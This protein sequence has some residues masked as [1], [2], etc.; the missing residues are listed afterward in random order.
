MNWWAANWGNIASVVGLVISVVAW[1]QAAAATILVQRSQARQ[2]LFQLSLVLERCTHLVQE[3]TAS[4]GTRLPR[5][6]C[7]ELRDALAEVSD[8]LLFEYGERM[9]LRTWIA[10]FYSPMQRTEQASS[11]IR[12]LKTCLI[13]VKSRVTDAIR[14]M[15]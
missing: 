2:R 12:E 1:K 7:D 9:L 15:E 4:T 14:R 11:Q 3:I 10:G 6:R 8:D 13:R 5:R